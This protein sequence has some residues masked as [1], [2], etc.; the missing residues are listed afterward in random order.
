MPKDKKTPS[1]NSN[2]N[3]H[4]GKKKSNFNNDNDHQVKKFN[5]FGLQQNLDG[6][7]RMHIDQTFSQLHHGGRLIFNQSLRKQLKKCFTLNSQQ[8]KLF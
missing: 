8:I 5:S 2:S 4:S 1:G 6:E 3:S 7:K